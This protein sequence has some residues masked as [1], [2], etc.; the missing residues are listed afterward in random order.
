M[1][2][3]HDTSAATVF[4]GMSACTTWFVL[5]D[6]FRLVS[7]FC[8]LSRRLERRLPVRGPSLRSGCHYLGGGL[9]AILTAFASLTAN[10]ATELSIRPA[11]SL[12]AVRM[13]AVPYG[14]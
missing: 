14:R 2:G 11:S 4:P 1:G 8:S 9:P 7:S 13:T 3:V 10:S 12:V 5:P 6:S